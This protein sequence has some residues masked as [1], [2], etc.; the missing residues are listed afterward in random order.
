M[1]EVQ[2]E[3]RSNGRVNGIGQRLARER[4]LTVIY[5][6]L[7]LLLVF[8]ICLCFDF[9]FDSVFTRAWVCTGGFDCACVCFL[10]RSG[11]C[12]LL[13]QVQN[14]TPEFFSPL[15]NWKASLISVQF[16]R[17]LCFDHLYWLWFFLLESVTTSLVWKPSK[18]SS[19][20]LNNRTWSPSALIHLA[21]WL[22]S[23]PSLVFVIGG[24][25]PG[26]EIGLFG[27]GRPPLCGGEKPLGRWGGCWGGVGG[28][29]AGRGGCW[30]AQQGGCQNPQSAAPPHRIHFPTSSFSSFASP[31]IWM[32][33][34]T[35]TILCICSTWMW[36]DRPKLET[37]FDPSQGLQ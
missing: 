22:V 21:L 28:G 1:V 29:R 23:F 16:G 4:V 35:L 2:W 33:Y 30:E 17:W 11:C 27:E 9:D 8:I 13:W 6:S 12:K 36:K 37:C 26:S 18:W 34:K 5:S 19:R 32:L 20:D 7:V 15:W 3:S 25:W 31:H 10:G 24:A 14:G